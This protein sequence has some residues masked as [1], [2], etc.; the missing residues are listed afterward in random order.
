MS[1][2][3]IAMSTA[4]RQVKPRGFNLLTR[5]VYVHSAFS[6]VVLASNVVQALTRGVPADALYAGLGVVIAVAVAVS[7]F[8]VAQRR[9]P[10]ALVWLRGLVWIAAVKVLLGL[11][12]V[13]SPAGVE[14]MGSLQATLVNEAVLIALALYWS[15]PVHG[16]YLAS[17][18]KS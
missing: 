2:F 13:I 12:A 18:A 7:M 16:R 6:L 11:F 14:T 8:G 5:I 10:L 9:S 17:L 3:A 4:L 15:R 1:L